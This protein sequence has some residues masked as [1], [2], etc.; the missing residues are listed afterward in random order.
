M[1]I[2]KFSLAQMTSNSDGKTSA[3]GVAG[4]LCIAAGVLCFLG[5][6]VFYLKSKDSQIMTQSLMLIG[7]GS[8]ILAYRKSKDS[9]LAQSL[10]DTEKDK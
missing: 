10:Q 2:N 5:G 1:D 3:S 8:A 6:A 9:Q 4:I 7:S